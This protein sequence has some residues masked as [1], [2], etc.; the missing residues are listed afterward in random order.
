MHAY[1][2]RLSVH[3]HARVPCVGDPVLLYERNEGVP[4]GNAMEWIL[5]ELYIMF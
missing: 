4:H 3:A 2:L 5:N 1:S